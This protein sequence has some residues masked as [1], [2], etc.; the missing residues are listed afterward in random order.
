MVKCVV[1][2]TSYKGEPVELLQRIS[3]LKKTIQENLLPY[4][5]EC[6]DD[7]LTE[8]QK[9]LIMILEVIEIGKCYGL[10]KFLM[11]GTESEY[12]WTCLTWIAGLKKQNSAHLLR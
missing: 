9:D 1:K 12:F 8:K 6:F 2:T 7:P 10:E 5:R 4:L 3:W 11:Y